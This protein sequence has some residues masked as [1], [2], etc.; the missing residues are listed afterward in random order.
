MIAARFQLT[1]PSFVLTRSTKPRTAVSFGFSLLGTLRLSPGS[2]D[3]IVV[4][5]VFSSAWRWARVAVLLRALAVLT[6]WWTTL[7]DAV[8]KLT[9]A[10]VDAD[11]F[12]ATRAAASTTG[13]KRYAGLTC[14]PPCSRGCART[15]SA[16]VRRPP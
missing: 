2:A 12:P 5:W 10:F 11:A 1:A 3:L 16:R 6:S 9:L 13:T 8:Q 15:G 14:G 7:F 4:N